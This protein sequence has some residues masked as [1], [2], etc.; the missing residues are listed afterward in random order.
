MLQWQGCRSRNGTGLARVSYC[1]HTHGRR[2]SC[3]IAKPCPE[4]ETNVPYEPLCWKSRADLGT[5]E[6][7]LADRKRVHVW[8]NKY[9]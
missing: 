3:S 9:S 2:L 1:V 4:V 5:E 6:S 7:F 8:G